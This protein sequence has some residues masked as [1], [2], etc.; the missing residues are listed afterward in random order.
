MSNPWVV[1]AATVLIIVLSAFFVAV[2]F[3]TLGAK[4]HRLEEAASSSRSARAALRSSRE[5]TVLLVGLALPDLGGQLHVT[6]C[7]GRRCW[8]SGPAGCR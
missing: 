6:G 7:S 2:E 8:F 1:V 5:L 3:A 4:R